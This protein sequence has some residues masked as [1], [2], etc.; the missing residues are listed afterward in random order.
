MNKRPI[1]ITILSILVL[2][3]GIGIILTQIKFYANLNELSTEL[4]ISLIAFF[5]SVLFLIVL[6]IG[7]GIGMWLGKKWGWW[8]GA[9]YYVHAI[10]RYVYALITAIIMNEQLK[11]TSRSAEYYL[12]TY[13]GRIVIH[14]LILRYYF[15]DNVMEYFNISS[16]SKVKSAL[17]VIV[18]G[19]AAHAI[20]SMMSIPQ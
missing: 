17:I 1:G 12:I 15:K 4:G 6:S 18:V 7:S 19:I 10:L 3:G 13:M 8:L 20:I 16:Y 2:V 11:D 14:A 9:F 5:V